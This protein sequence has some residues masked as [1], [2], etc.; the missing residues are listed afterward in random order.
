M[1]VIVVPNSKAGR[2]RL[3]FSLS[4]SVSKETSLGAN[5]IYPFTLCEGE[6]E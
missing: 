1:L 2:G 6:A 5:I 4:P 3:A